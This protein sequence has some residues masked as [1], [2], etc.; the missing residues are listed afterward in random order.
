MI[1]KKSLFYFTLSA[2]RTSYFY[3]ERSWIFLMIQFMK[4]SQR[5]E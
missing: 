1:K 3:K 2:F 4:D 5:F